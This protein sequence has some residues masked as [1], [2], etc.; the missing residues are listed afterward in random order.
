MKKCENKLRKLLN[1][2]MF[3]WLRLSRKMYIYTDKALK[4]DS[5]LMYNRMETEH[6]RM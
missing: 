6:K 3:H 5:N 2:G 4:G 1:K